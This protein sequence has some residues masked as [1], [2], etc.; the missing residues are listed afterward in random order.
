MSIRG[1]SRLTDAERINQAWRVLIR[2]AVH[3]DDDLS[4]RLRDAQLSLRRQ[5][6][7][8]LVDDIVQVIVQP[9]AELERL[10]GDME[11]DGAHSELAALRTLIRN[12]ILVG[13]P[14]PMQHDRA[15][16]H[17]EPTGSNRNTTEPDAVSER[18]DFSLGYQ[19]KAEWRRSIAIV[20]NSIQD[21]NCRLSSWSGQKEDMS[22]VADVVDAIQPFLPE[23]QRNKMT[24]EQLNLLCEMIVEEICNRTVS[25]VEAPLYTFT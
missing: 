20:P 5:D 6:V 10:W 19:C 7:D 23:D 2:G 1:S 21:V 18:K 22:L 9:K 3:N 16:A 15:E 4:Q 25:A 11:R 14:I 17:T 24:D 8:A 12:E 13:K